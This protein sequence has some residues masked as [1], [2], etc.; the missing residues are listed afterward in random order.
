MTQYT[1]KWKGYPQRHLPRIRA[2]SISTLNSRRS[3]IAAQN[4]VCL[5]FGLDLEKARKERDLKL[6]RRRNR[7]LRESAKETFQQR[8]PR[9][10]IH[11]IEVIRWNTSRE[12]FARTP[13]PFVELPNTSS[14]QSISL[15]NDAPSSVIRPRK[16][17]LQDSPFSLMQ[18]AEES[19]YGVGMNGELCE[20]PEK[21]QGRDTQNWYFRSEYAQTAAINRLRS[22]SIYR[23]QHKIASKHAYA[24]RLPIRTFL[25]PTRST[26]SNTNPSHCSRRSS[27]VSRSPKMTNK[28]SAT[29]VEFRK[30]PSVLS[31]PV[32]YRPTEALPTVLGGIP[33]R[34][35]SRRKALNKFTRGLEKHIVAQ[36]ALR[37]ASLLTTTSTSDDS[38]HTILEF[39]PY[40]AEFQAN[41][42]AVTSSDQR[43]R[44][45]LKGDHSPSPLPDPLRSSINVR[46]TPP[47]SR[48]D[49]DASTNKLVEAPCPTF[50]DTVSSCSTVIAFS[51]EMVPQLSDAPR[52]TSFPIQT[53]ST[54]R[55]LPWLRKDNCL[56]TISPTL[57]TEELT[58]SSS[59]GLKVD[60][61]PKITGKGQT[62]V[63][64]KCF[65]FGSVIKLTLIF[66]RSTTTCTSLQRNQMA[67][68]RLQFLLDTACTTRTENEHAF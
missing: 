5:P 46:N 44:S 39:M 13:I 3:H 28:S 14:I 9:K 58:E 37:R 62:K 60:S 20:E 1:F 43:K 64:C 32:T 66:S 27:T 11:N 29:N 7:N 40:I 65:M 17:D 31:R 15:I 63:L 54:R 57:K 6:R 48:S 18:V 24:N 45:P 12:K 51:T 49:N 25:Q 34:S 56:K 50:S 2:A 38:T 21:P 47:T 10:G 61:G 55:T 16:P 26:P 52:S 42:L 22:R 59:I 67:H 30:A 8:S 35:S 36:K 4:V 23:L 33:S 53:S 19:V 41:G 68:S